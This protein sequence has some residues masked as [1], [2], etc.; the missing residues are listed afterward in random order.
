MFAVGLL[1]N[2]FDQV[3]DNAHGHENHPAKK[4][5]MMPRPA[6]SKPVTIC[7]ATLKDAK[8]WSDFMFEKGFTD[9]VYTVV[10]GK[11]AKASGENQ[12]AR[13]DVTAYLREQM[14]G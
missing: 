3:L 5:T 14:E 12:G 11:V 10:D 7:E 13:H 6:A 8:D 4:E 9:V 1:P 2:V